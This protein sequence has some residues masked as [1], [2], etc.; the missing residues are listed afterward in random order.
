M[1][2]RDGGEAQ[3]EEFIQREEEI[4]KS[5]RSLFESLAGMD[6][7][8][9][10]A[11]DEVRLSVDRITAFLSEE[12]ADLF[13]KALQGSVG[14]HVT[15]KEETIS[16]DTNEAESRWRKWASKD[17]SG[18]PETINW[19]QYESGFAHVDGDRE[20]FGSYGFLHHDVV[21]GKP[22][23]V[24]AGVLAAGDTASGES[25][26]SVQR[27]LTPHYG[28]FE[29]SAPWKNDGEIK[30]GALD[31]FLEW[32]GANRIV[33]N[34]AFEKA[35]ER[36]WPAFCVAIAGLMKSDVDPKDKQ[37]QAAKLVADLQIKVASTT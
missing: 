10:E 36:E 9:D 26:K 30:K 34:A 29:H 19:K 15:D 5:V 33:E 1:K 24:R 6:A 31:R 21:N 12:Y 13:D 37:I 17:G 25:N 3:L 16:W 4:T 2:Q 22:V 14:T 32:S 20:Q 11:P 18:E 27:H 35:L 28:Q 7:Y 23:V 8:L